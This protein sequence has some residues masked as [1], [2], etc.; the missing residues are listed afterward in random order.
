[1]MTKIYRPSPHPRLLIAALVVLV[2]GCIVVVEE[3]D[4]RRDRHR[5]L[6]AE[7]SVDIIVYKTETI[8]A[9]EEDIT[10]TFEESG[11]LFAA[12]D[13]SEITGSFEV[14]DSNVLTV[15]DVWTRDDCVRGSRTT[16]LLSRAISGAY[17]YEADETALRI[18]TS[19]DGLIGLSSR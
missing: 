13:C 10:V 8:S 14:D 4:D 12:T 2:S 15:S 6:Y 19:E 16:D 18:S 7:W 5:H 1:M 17:S 11:R 3:D 9:P